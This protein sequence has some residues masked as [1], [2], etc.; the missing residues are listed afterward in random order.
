MI[1]LCN[2]CKKEIGKEYSDLLREAKEYYKDERP[3]LSDAD[4]TLRYN[5]KDKCE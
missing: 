1:L 3:E 5:T 2:V 4:V